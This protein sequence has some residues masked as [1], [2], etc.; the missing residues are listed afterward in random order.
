M[1]KKSRFEEGIEN[2][3]EELGDIGERFGKRMER[4]ARRH[5]ER[6][7][8]HKDSLGIM[9]PFVS[10][11]LNLLLIALCIWVLGFGW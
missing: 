6:V 10:S 9:S 7:E 11:L 1:P 8:R 2:F 4:G 3:A 5:K